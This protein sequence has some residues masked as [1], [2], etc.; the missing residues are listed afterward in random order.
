MYIHTQHHSNR[1]SPTAY[2]SC[3]LEPDRSPNRV[4]S[5][6]TTCLPLPPGPFK[7]GHL[8]PPNRANSSTA[9]HVPSPPGPFE[10][11]RSSP[12][13]PCL[14]EH[15]HSSPASTA[16]GPFQVQLLVSTQLCQFKRNC[17]CPTLHQVLS[18]PTARL[19]P[20]RLSPASIRPFRVQLLV[21]T[22]PCRV[23]R[24]RLSPASALSN[25]VAC[26]PTTMPIRARL[27]VSH[28]HRVLEPDRSP[29]TQPCPFKPGRSSPTQPCPSLSTTARPVSTALF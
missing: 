9:A 22:Q 17:L 1:V 28:L 24:S 14:F 26:L 23:E 8:S 10:P 27:L 13:Q 5:S 21:P 4:H 6:V 25:M 18:S 19:R 12:T 29:P 16:S 7:S 3:P 2:R 15:N 20:K 11:D